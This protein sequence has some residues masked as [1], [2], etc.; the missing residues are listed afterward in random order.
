MAVDSVDAAP[1]EDQRGFLSIPDVK[2]WRSIYSSRGDEPRRRRAADAMLFVFGAA[3][4]LMAS[5]IA[6]S[7]SIGEAD[8]AADLANLLDWLDPIWR[9]AYVITAILI[10]AL[11]AVA[12]ATKRRALGLTLVAA[13]VIVVGVSE[14]VA[15][16]VEGE[17]ASLGALFTAGDPTFPAVRIAVATAVVA[18]ARPDLSRPVR[19]FGSAVVVVGTLAAI[20]LG[21]SSLSGALAAASVG[22]LVAAA[23]FLVLG[24]HAGFPPERRV[25][26]SLAELGLAVGSLEPT[27]VQTAGVATYGTADMAGRELVVKVYGRDA[28][29]SQFLAR[30][31]RTLWYRDAGRQIATSRV[32]QVEHEALCTLAAQRAGVATQDVVAVGGVSSGDAVIVL[33]KVDG[34]TLAHLPADAVSD[35]VLEQAWIG[36]ARLHQARI[37]HSRIELDRLTVGDERVVIGDLAAAR[38]GARDSDRAVDVAELLV[39]TA[40]VVGPE[41]ALGA[42]RASIGDE[43]LTDAL[44]YLQ[45]AALTPALRDQVHDK[46]LKVGD[47]RTQVATALGVELMP[48]AELRRVTIKGVLAVGLTAFAA[49]LIIGQL[50]DIGLSTIIDELQ[51]ASWQWLVLILFLAQLPL[52]SQAL[53]LTGAVPAPIPYAPTVA[54]ESGIKFVNL[55]VPSSAGRI[56]VNIRYLQKQGLS[57]TS[58]V[59][60][61]SLDGVAGT[62]VQILLLLLILP[63]ISMDLDVDVGSDLSALMWIVIAGVIAVVAAAV[64]LIVKKDWREK[65]VAH[66][67]EAF[68]C[69]KSVL[70]APGKLVRLFGGN[71]LTEIGWA[72]CLAAS[73]HA[74]GADLGLAQA[75][76][77]NM[78]ASVL[79]SVIPVPGG[80]GVAEA[81]LAAG[82]MAFGVPQSEAYAAAL[83]HRLATF[84]LPPIWGWFSLR[85]LTRKGYL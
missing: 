43:A 17:W 77:V 13:V 55:T 50:S 79:A 62:I 56:A 74:Y 48:I 46:G 82:M 68:G 65:V 9:I 60:A 10:A 28:R 35:D 45:P 23:I 57:A 2:A 84:Y 26:A 18:V 1:T 27:A 21:E 49:W 61:G 32:R 12:F 67:R 40:L 39:S 38:L 70:V 24:S 37:A 4:L 71:V 41:R 78:F 47:L 54:L 72:L 5:L 22:V 73:A 64:V 15:R 83:T 36:V 16:I 29:D 30:V 53:A 75:L 76:V 31:W 80:I 11:I 25:R 51:E 69:L 3:G 66:L 85:W 14:I 81:S 58:A 42:A 33:E 20:V 19:R 34:L 8:A 52:A 63:F 6:S 7:D 44:P 59:A